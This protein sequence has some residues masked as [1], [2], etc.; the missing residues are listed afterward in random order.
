MFDASIFGPAPTGRPGDSGAVSAAQFDW[1]VPHITEVETAET[2]LRP[3]PT[4]TVFEFVLLV[5]GIGVPDLEDVTPKLF[6][7]ARVQG[8]GSLETDVY[9]LV[10]RR[11]SP[12]D[13]L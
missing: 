3:P 12:S 8:A 13:I 2:L 11:Q 6:D 5:E 7:L 4:A 9:R 1:H 10:R